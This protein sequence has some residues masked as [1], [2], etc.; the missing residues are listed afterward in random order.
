MARKS[1]RKLFLFGKYSLALLPP[2]KWLKELGIKEGDYAQLE[3]DKTRGRIVIRFTAEGESP[4]TPPSTA[5]EE[6]SGQGWQP[7]PEL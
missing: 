2:K 1:Q 4:A 7:V 6:E 5:S 3:F